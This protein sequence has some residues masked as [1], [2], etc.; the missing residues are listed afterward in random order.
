LKQ[1]KSVVFV[2][3][4]TDRHTTAM[5]VKSGLFRNVRAA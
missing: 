3:M 4:P 5:T 2:A 1:E